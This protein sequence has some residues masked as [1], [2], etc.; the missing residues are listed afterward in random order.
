MS[1][2]T[3]SVE[4][5][6]KKRQR[7][8]CKQRHHFYG[9]QCILQCIIIDSASKS[10]LSQRQ[11]IISILRLLHYCLQPLCSRRLLKELVRPPTSV[12]KTTVLLRMMKAQNNTLYNGPLLLPNTANPSWKW[13]TTAEDDILSN[14]RPY[15]YLNAV[16]VNYMYT[17]LDSRVSVKKRNSIG[18]EVINE[19]QATQFYLPSFGD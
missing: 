13:R 7:Y 1:V 6:L 15:A 4:K 5:S 2:G 8:S 19:R 18:V 9:S 10:M 16:E 3:E 17:K 11:I 12:S 14:H